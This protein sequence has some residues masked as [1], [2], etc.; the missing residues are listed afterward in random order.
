MQLDASHAAASLTSLVSRWCTA[1]LQQQASHGASIKL[2]CT[3]SSSGC[4]RKCG[5]VHSAMPFSLHSP[6]LDDHNSAVQVLSSTCH[7][8]KAQ[9][10]CAACMCPW[11]QQMH[12]VSRR[13]C[14]MASSAG[15]PA[16]VLHI[17]AG[18][19]ALRSSP[20]PALHD[21]HTKQ[22]RSQDRLAA[23][24][25]TQRCACRLPECAAAALSFAHS[26]SIGPSCPAGALCSH[27][28]CSKLQLWWSCM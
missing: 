27:T 28:S 1:A 10:L 9:P 11:P 6:S 4:T 12:C 26:C 15:A 20:F 22:R 23:W 24:A 8:S 5:V 16:D 2:M 3:S 19:P 13:A 14:C 17:H 25:Q 21:P 18:E 7:H